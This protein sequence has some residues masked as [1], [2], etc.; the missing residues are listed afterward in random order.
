MI[1]AYFDSQIVSP[2]SYCLNILVS[3]GY[4]FIFDLRVR[5]IKRAICL[6]Q[7]ETDIFGTNLQSNTHKIFEIHDCIQS[8]QIK[9]K[10]FKV[11]FSII[12]IFSFDF[13]KIY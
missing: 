13:A 12:S 5:L 4:L 11:I 2:F 8:N 3:V 9:L 7:S 10:F 6:F 1:K